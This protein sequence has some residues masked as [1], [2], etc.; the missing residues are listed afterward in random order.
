MNLN[1]FV[2]MS[3]M[4]DG[5]AVSI[6]RIRR[7][8][9]PLFDAFSMRVSGLSFEISTKE[10]FYEVE[11]FAS[12]VCDAN[13]VATAIE[14]CAE[15][16]KL[17]ANFG[18]FE[19]T[20][21]R[22]ECVIEILRGKVDETDAYRLW[23]GSPYRAYLAKKAFAL[24]SAMDKAEIFSRDIQKIMDMSGLGEIRRGE[25]TNAMDSVSRTLLGMYKQEVVVYMANYGANKL[26]CRMW[27]RI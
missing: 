10:D 1:V 27:R 23:V 6:S 19:L 20:A 16:V 8:F 3:R 15:N 22:P 17:L 13:N 21:I 18:V 4:K 11:L 5:K 2:E 14:I 24:Q 7:M 12:D 25:V 9:E 26:P